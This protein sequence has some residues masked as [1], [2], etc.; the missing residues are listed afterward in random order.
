MVC[1]C[2]SSTIIVICFDCEHASKELNCIKMLC[3]TKL[4]N[5][6]KACDIRPQQ[7]N[8]T[9]IFAFHLAYI[10]LFFVSSSTI[11]WIYRKR[12]YPCHISGAISRYILVVMQCV[13]NAIWLC[14]FSCLVHNCHIVTQKDRDVLLDHLLLQLIA[15][16]SR[17]DGTVLKPHH[18]RCAETSP[19]AVFSHSHIKGFSLNFQLKFQ[20]EKKFIPNKKERIYSTLLGDYLT[21]TLTTRDN[22]KNR[23]NKTYMN[24]TNNHNLSLDV[25]S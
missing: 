23:S 3:A 4:A 11:V 9:I 22:K 12:R 24:T 18:I 14:F 7:I 13:N 21:Y 17:W 5:H 2:C 1:M 6:H 19:L 15:K 10:F 8:S 16:V 20:E 25:K